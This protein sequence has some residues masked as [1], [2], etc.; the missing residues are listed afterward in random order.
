MTDKNTSLFKEFYKVAKSKGLNSRAIQ[1]YSEGKLESISYGELFTKAALVNKFLCD[2]GIKTKD[3]VGIISEN[4][5]EWTISDLATISTGIINVPTF[6]NFTA[7]QQKFIFNDCDVKAIILSSKLQLDKILSIKSELEHLKLVLVMDDELEDL[8]NN[9]YSFHKVLSRYANEFKEDKVVEDLIE[10]SQE[11]NLDSIFTLIYTSGTT[12]NPK[13]VTLL[14]R[15]V[16]S[17]VKSIQKANVINSSDSFLSFLPMCHA[18]ERT[19]VYTF[20][21][22]GALVTIAQSLDTLTSNINEV[23]PTIVTAVPKLLETIRNKVNNAFKNETDSKKKIIYKALD[24]SITRLDKK[25]ST[26]EKLK[27][28]VYDKLVYSIIRAKLGGNLKYIISGGAALQPEVQ[29]F[30]HSVGINILQGYGLTECSPVVS[31]NRPTQLEIGTVGPP[32]DGVEVRIDDNGEILVRGDLVMKGYWHD[33]FATKSSIDDH[34]WYYTG[35]IGEFTESGS[36]KITGRIKSIIVTSGGK[37]ISPSPI[38]D[39]IRMSDYVEHIAIF[40]EGQDY[41]IGIVSPDN[42]E[43][44][45]LAKTLGLDESD[46]EELIK[47]KKIMSKIKKDIDSHQSSLSKFERVRKIGLVATPFSIDGGELTPKMSLKKSNIEQKFKPMIDGLY[48]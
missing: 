4:R 7:E 6:P 38:E 42:D 18:Y 32:L 2:N 37:N 41:L 19:V 46:F 25:L 11:V 45:N 24:Y 33:D 12:G 40:G 17:N 10:K 39:L 47:N 21:L 28:K 13:G 29:R 36:L 44:K 15:N 9:V 16:V 26:L 14:N 35:D 43:V 30:F 1:Y 3:R 27:L 5:I 22:T 20:F 48:K 23:R 34:G 31:V 8:D